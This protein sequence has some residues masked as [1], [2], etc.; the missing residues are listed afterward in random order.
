MW[1]LAL[2]WGCSTA[3]V[4][5][6]ETPAPI[7]VPAEIEVAPEP[8]A[9]PAPVWSSSIEGIPPDLAQRMKGVSWREGCPTPMADL[10]LLTLPHYDF[11]GNV[12]QGQ[13]VVHHEAAGAVTE[14]F[15]RAFLEQFPIRS[16]RPVSEF[17]G[18]DDKSMAADNT[19]AFNCRPIKGTSR[20]SEHSSGKAIDVNPRENPWVKGDKVDP[21]EGREFL[22]RDGSTKGVL[23]AQSG[24]TRAFLGAG[25]GWGGTWKS[26]KD[27]QHFSESGR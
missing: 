13:L 15:A 19:S 23:T 5:G 20:W 16:M 25:W 8:V 26:L 12:V 17:E 9:Q 7:E 2:L 14:A 6:I 21:P 1:T 10:R 11:D 22:D 27:Y 4:P 3:P 18:S 24:M